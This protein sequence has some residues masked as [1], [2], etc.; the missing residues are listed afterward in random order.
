MRLLDVELSNF[1]L[2]RVQQ[3]LLWDKA[4]SHFV[5]YLPHLAVL[6]LQIIGASSVEFDD[7]TLSQDTSLSTLVEAMYMAVDVLWDGISS[8]CFPGDRQ[9][10]SFDIRLDCFQ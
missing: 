6:I 8:K 1:C 10:S 2:S 5:S 7:V 4:L 3:L 9:L